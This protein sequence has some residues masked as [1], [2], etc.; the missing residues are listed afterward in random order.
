[1][2]DSEAFLGWPTIVGRLLERGDLDDSTAHA[3]VSQIL[4]GEATSAQM[5]AFL[6]AL[7]AKGETS[8]ELQAMLRAVREASVSVSLSDEVA[9]RAM[10]IVGTG[11]DK[12]NSVNVSTMSALI[13]AAAGV[14]V[15]KH[16]NRASSSACGSADVLE[17]VGVAIG[18]D[19]AGVQ[20]CVEEV[21]FG[22]CLASQF[23]PAFRHVGPTRRELGVPTAFNLLGPM[24]NPAPISAML[25]GV[26]QPA[27]MEN[28]AHV[29]LSRNVTRAWIVHG[30]GGLDELSL[31]GPNTVCD[32]NNGK[33][34][35]ITVDAADFGIARADVSEIEGGDAAMNAA[36]LRAVFAGQTGPVRDIVVFNAGCA[37]LLSGAVSKIEEGIAMVRA[38]LDSGAAQKLLDAVIAVSTREAQRMEASS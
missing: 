32:V 28:M 15:C 4:H 19:A 1:M 30:H 2:A 31:S 22:F 16:G 20:A 27:L 12:S 35:M 25:V 23:H 13:V 26:A 3:A 6:I 17:A 18:L 21:G 38:T 5:A 37:L 10:D 24:A 7:R 33:I 36:T 8:Q 11:G 9:H 29:L 14:P 34:S